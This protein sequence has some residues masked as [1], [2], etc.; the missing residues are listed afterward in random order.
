MVTVTKPSALRAKRLQKQAALVLAAHV[1]AKTAKY[2]AVT[3]AYQAQQAALA[4]QQAALAEIAQ[5][6]AKYGVSVQLTAQPRANS[7]TPAPSS[8]AIL[9]NGVYYN[10]CKAVHAICAMHSTRKAA[11]AACI[12]AGINPATA[13][14]QYGIYHKKHSTK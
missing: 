8:A 3:Q 13:S 7:A 6:Q 14:T 5:I 12:A 10:P 4:N 9:V 11:I 1:Q 2:Q